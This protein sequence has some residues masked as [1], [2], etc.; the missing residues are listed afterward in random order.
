MSLAR[1]LR[2]S[3]KLKFDV[4][5]YASLRFVLVRDVISWIV[6]FGV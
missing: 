5:L 4:P 1:L 3:V 2:D 6:R